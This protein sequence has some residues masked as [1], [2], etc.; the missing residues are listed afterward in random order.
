MTPRLK[1]N[2]RCLLSFVL[3]AIFFAVFLVLAAGAIFT[4]AAFC[5]LAAVAFAL[6]AAFLLAIFAAVA[7]AEHP[8]DEHA[9]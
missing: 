2:R 4:L 6:F 7:A 9:P 5:S 1:L 3:A 8:F